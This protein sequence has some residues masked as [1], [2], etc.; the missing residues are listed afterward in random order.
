MTDYIQGVRNNAGLILGNLSTSVQN[1]YTGGGAYRDKGSTGSTWPGGANQLFYNMANLAN[2]TNGANTSI[3]TWSALNNNDYLE[4]QLYALFQVSQCNT[5][6]PVA[7][8]CKPDAEL[9]CCCRSML[10]YGCPCTSMRPTMP[11]TTLRPTTC[12]FCRAQPSIPPAAEQFQLQLRL[13]SQRH[14][15]PAVVRRLPWCGLI[16]LWSCMNIGRV[17]RVQW[18]ACMLAQHLGSL[19]AANMFCPFIAA[20]GKNPICTGFLCKC[21]SIS[22]VQ[23]GRV[24]VAEAQ[25]T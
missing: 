2:G 19:A 22:R 13:A 20:T 16:Y 14:K 6:W 7:P 9:G 10:C 1:L 12:R 3:N 8:G 17:L 15:D 11:P 21:I 25:R 18:L 4:A 23:E 5:L 24:G